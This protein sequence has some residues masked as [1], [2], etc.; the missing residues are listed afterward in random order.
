MRHKSNDDL[1][2]SL[3]QSALSK[4]ETGVS[5]VYNSFYGFCRETYSKKVFE[6][7]VMIPFEDMMVPAPKDYETVLTQL[8]GDWR[9]LPP[10]KDRY[11][12]GLEK[13]VYEEK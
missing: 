2:A 5:T 10:V 12:E 3:K 1:R 7:Y 9:T 13:M 4:T 8:Y 11:P 6:D